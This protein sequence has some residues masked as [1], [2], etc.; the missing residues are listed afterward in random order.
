[1]GTDPSPSEGLPAHPP[2]PTYPCCLPALGE[3]SGMTPRG[4]PGITLP[5]PRGSAH[6][7]PPEGDG[8]ASTGIGSIDSP[9]EDSPSGL[10]RTI[11]NRVGLTPS[12]VQIPYPP[13]VREPGVTSIV[14]SGS[15]R[16]RTLRR[17]GAGG[18][19][20]RGLPSSAAGAPRV[21]S[22]GRPVGGDP[23]THRSGDYDN[24]VRHAGTLRSGFDGPRTVELPE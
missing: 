2:E 13:P 5:V 17:S 15:R 7:R 3:F 20:R 1:M 10:G 6:R 9:V 19:G 4:E 24:A 12:G 11:G 18:C 21:G 14:T 16:L 23:I 8:G 22:R